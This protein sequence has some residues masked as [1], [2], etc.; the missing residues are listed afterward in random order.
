MCALSCM[1]A[2]TERVIGVFSQVL[3]VVILRESTNKCT[4]MKH[5]R[6]AGPTLWLPPDPPSAK[7]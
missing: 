2:N 6:L 3:S 5:D 4:E 1:F 7:R